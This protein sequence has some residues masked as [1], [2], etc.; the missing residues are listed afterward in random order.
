MGPKN[1]SCKIIF[2][3]CAFSVLNVEHVLTLRPAFMTTEH[4]PF[5]ELKKTILNYGQLQPNDIH[6]AHVFPWSAIEECVDKYW[7]PTAAPQNVK[8]LNDFIKLI[9]KVDTVAQVPTR[10]D[11]S[12]NP[13]INSFTDQANYLAGMPVM[14]VDPKTKKSIKV[15]DMLTTNTQM[16]N[17]AL[18]IVTLKHSSYSVQ[19][20]KKQLKRLLNSAPA[21]LRLASGVSN[22]DISDRLDP[23]GNKQ[24]KL[25]TKEQDL[26]GK[27]GRGIGACAAKYQD[28]V[29]VCKGGAAYCHSKANG[30]YVSSSSS[31]SKLVKIY[32]L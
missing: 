31:R 15:G 20:N 1:L 30:L 16:E 23:L 11:R 29:A 22:V 32:K 17:K 26:N 21:N 7:G 25:T 5:F 6:L 27:F 3:F 2:L 13:V 19:K 9:F 8:G 10:F 28:I 18:N 14:K 24:E 4:R 12:E